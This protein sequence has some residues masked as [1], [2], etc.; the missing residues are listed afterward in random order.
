MSATPLAAG[1]VLPPAHPVLGIDVSKASLTCSLV[2]P[3]TERCRWTRQFAN[4]PAGITQ[5]LQHT[6]AEAAWVLEPTGRYSTLVAQQA[7]TAGRRVLLA[8]PKRAKEFLRSE[9]PRV[10]TDRVDSQGLALYGL[11]RPLRPYPLKSATMEQLD[12]L[13]AARK[14]LSLALSR[15]ELQ[16]QN[17]P[18]AAETLRA[19][20]ADLQARRAELDR[21]I[22]ALLADEAQFPMAQKLQAIP[23]IGPVTAA[24]V[25][26]C[27][28][29]KQFTHPDQFVAFTGLAITRHESGK[30]TGRGQ[31]SKQG[32]GELRRLLYLAAQSSLRCKES[33]FKARYERERAKGLSTTGALCAVARKLARLCWSMWKYQTDYDPARVHQQPERFGGRPCPAPTPQNS[34]GHEP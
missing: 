19:A 5:L 25:L 22:A 31:L 7:A 1:T 3:G 6:P 8:Q 2:E 30:R 12:Q 18:Y 32:P 20:R 24:A 15:L 28:T 16:L 10:K 27:L 9:R 29:Q 23:G 13:Q 17:L 21:Q 11:C 33:P 26:S 34:P 4:T 14:G